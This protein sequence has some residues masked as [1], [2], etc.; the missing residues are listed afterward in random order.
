MRAFPRPILLSLLLTL[1]AC[2]FQPLYGGDHGRAVTDGLARVELPTAD[3]RAE[4]I[5][6]N[7]LLEL[8][9]P[10]VA[11]AL[12]RLESRI[13]ISE[14]GFAIESDA[15]ASRFNVI[16]RVSYQLMPLTASADDAATDRAAGEDEAEQSGPVPLTAGTVRR[17]GSYD[18]LRS[19]YATLIA[20]QDAVNRVLQ[21]AAREVHTRLGLYLRRQES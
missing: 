4:Q 21:D 14:T 5:Y 11:D 10:G 19:K 8:T 16:V 6:R 20:R 2:G 7:T 18:A 1:A 12:Y 3:N 17:I 15:T 13:G 9:Q